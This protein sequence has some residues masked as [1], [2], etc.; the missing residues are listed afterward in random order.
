[1]RDIRR[2]DVVERLHF[3]R[4]ERAVVDADVVDGAFYIGSARAQGGPAPTSD[5]NRLIVIPKLRN[6]DS[7][8]PTL[9]EGD[10]ILNMSQ[11]KHLDGRYKLAATSQVGRG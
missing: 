6:L 9:C 7:C 1:V 3:G 4:G 10:R 11:I 8:Y 2:A 5:R